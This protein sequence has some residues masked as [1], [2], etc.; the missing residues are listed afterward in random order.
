MT[1]EYRELEMKNRQIQRSII[2][3]FKYDLSTE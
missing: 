2:I 1:L 3:T